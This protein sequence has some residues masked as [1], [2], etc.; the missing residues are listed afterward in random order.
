MLLESRFWK[1][2]HRVG[3]VVLDPT[4]AYSSE[5]LWKVG[6][7]GPEKQSIKQTLSSTE[8]DE[9]KDPS[10]G[11]GRAGGEGHGPYTWTLEGMGLVSS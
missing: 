2:Q 7:R 8:N 4:L 1:K 5:P 10:W 3:E 6:F 11:W 9:S